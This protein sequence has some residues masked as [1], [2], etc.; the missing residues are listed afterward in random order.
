MGESTPSRTPGNPANSYTGGPDRAVDI[1]RPR[2]F[3][4]RQLLAAAREFEEP[5][6]IYGV[7]CFLIWSSIIPPFS[8]YREFPLQYS[9]SSNY[10]MAASTVVALPT[11]AIFVIFP[12][13]IVESIKTTGVK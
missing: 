2:H 3:L 5:A 13:H 6:L 9:G 4:L 10:V 12:K 8:R 11:I 1:R 7:G